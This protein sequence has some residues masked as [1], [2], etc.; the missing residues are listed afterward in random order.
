VT[1]KQIRSA[2]P[3]AIA[4]VR[5]IIGDGR[6]FRQREQTVAKNVDFDVWTGKPFD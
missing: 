3:E 2:V 4:A 1:R 6:S 5:E